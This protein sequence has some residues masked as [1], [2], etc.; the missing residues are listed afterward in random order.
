MRRDGAYAEYVAV[1]QHIL[2]RLPDSLGFRQAAMVEPVAVA[3]HAVGRSGVR[4]GDTAV[5][6]GAG[7]IGLFLV[8]ALRAA[9]CRWIIAVD[10]DQ[11]KLD[12]ACKFGADDGLRPDKT[13]VAAEVMHRT[14]GHG[15]D[16]AMEAGRHCFH[17]ADG[18]GVPAKRR[19]VNARGSL[20]LEGRT[21]DSND[22]DA[23]VDYQQL[24][25]IVRRVSACLDL[26][27][28]RHDQRRSL[29]ERRCTT[30]RRTGVVPAASG[31]WRRAYQGD[32]GTVECW[33]GK[34]GL[35]AGIRFHSNS[36]GK[37]VQSRRYDF[38]TGALEP[39]SGSSATLPTLWRTT[40]STKRSCGARSKTPTRSCCITI[41]D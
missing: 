2:Y 1:P 11:E 8:Q 34:K 14:D 4:L 28:A 38:I 7:V 33:I 26:I 29:D 30:G 36:N 13:D 24:V 6:V 32:S 17:R 25:H 9:G 22:R 15:A 35:Q 21:A 23:R 31:R 3:V 41:S 19:P 5:V 27:G 37:E 39:E 12:L 20:G 18:D 10:L 40:G 16:V